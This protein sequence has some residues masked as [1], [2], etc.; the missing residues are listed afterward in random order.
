MGQS[1]FL[2]YN[3]SG[4]QG[5][6]VYSQNTSQ[7][8]LAYSTIELDI[9]LQ[10]NCPISDQLSGLIP[11]PNVTLMLHSCKNMAPLLNLYNV[12][13]SSFGIEFEYASHLSLSHSQVYFKF[14]SPQLEMQK[15]EISDLRPDYYQQSQIILLNSNLILNDVNVTDWRFFLGFSLHFDFN[16][17]ILS[18]LICSS[19]SFCN[20]TNSI[21][22]GT[23]KFPGSAESRDNAN[24]LFFNSTIHTNCTSRQSSYL[25]FEKSIIIKG[26][27]QIVPTLYALETGIIILEDAIMLSEFNTETS[28]AAMIVG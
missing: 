25:R 20:V 7:V 9:I 26:S 11:S 12:A 24:L 19:G 21:M 4:T 10:Y 2:G 17:C 5:G 13:V 6:L 15:N 23:D 27:I 14:I 8:N 1:F 28:R 16:N 18:E 22:Q 3:L